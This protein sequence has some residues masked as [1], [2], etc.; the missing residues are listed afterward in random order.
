[1][2][3]FKVRT[4]TFLIV[5]PI[6]IIIIIIGAYLIYNTYLIQTPAPGEV[7]VDVTIEGGKMT[8]SVIKVIQGSN[9]TLRIVSKDVE[10][11][12]H[13]HGGY[14]LEV[15]I[16]KNTPAVISFKAAYPGRATIALHLDEKELELGV[17]EVTPR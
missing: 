6:I 2:S 12:F 14:N 3:V 5:I 11:V 1:M 15:K 17:L 4:S 8:P 13:I 10:G 16:T 9:V 7:F